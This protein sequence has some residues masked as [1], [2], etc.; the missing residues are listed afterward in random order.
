MKVRV[1]AT[2]TEAKRDDGSSVFVASMSHSSGSMYS[3]S[4]IGSTRKAALERLKGNI[5]GSLEQSRIKSI[6]K[7]E[8]VFDVDD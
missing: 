5:E 8:L 2:I 3:A 4:G 7:T 6:E 1:E